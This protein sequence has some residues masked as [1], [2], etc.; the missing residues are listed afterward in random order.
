MHCVNTGQTSTRQ[1]A[2]FQFYFKTACADYFHANTLIDCVRV[3][4]CTNK[5]YIYSVTDATS[6]RRKQ[7]S[8]RFKLLKSSQTSTYVY[9]HVLLEIL[10][11][12]PYPT[13]GASILQLSALATRCLRHLDFGP[14]SPNIFSRT[15][16]A[17]FV[18][19]TLIELTKSRFK[20]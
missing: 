10:E 11:E 16:P 12:H 17:Y 8:R 20:S 15:V 14:Q 1:E 19:I 3:F 7:V 5:T 18:A 2:S 6:D 9:C 13:L 4:F